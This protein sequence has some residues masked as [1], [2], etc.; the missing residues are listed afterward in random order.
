MKR[1]KSLQSKIRNSKFIRLE[2]LKRGE[3]CKLLIKACTDGIGKRVCYFLTSCN[4]F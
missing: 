2:I 3:S 1:A 4:Y